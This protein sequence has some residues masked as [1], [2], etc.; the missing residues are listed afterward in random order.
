[1]SKP[2][3]AGAATAW[4]ADP[5]A[6]WRAASA[7]ATDAVQRGVLFADIERQVGDQYFAQRASKT[8]NVLHFPSAFV[9]SGLDLPRPV[10]YGLVRILPPENQPCDPAKRP[11]VVVDPR[12]GHGPG[13]GGFKP[14]SE[15]G[16]A[17]AA[18]H[19]CYFV[20]FLPDPVPGQ[21]VEDVMRAE[22]AFLRR[23][24]ELHPESEGKPAV[25]GNCQA[26]WQILMTA[27]VW[28]EL[29]GPIIVAGAPLSYWAGDNPMRY[30]GGLLGGSWLT[31]L[32]SDLGHGRFD[33]ANLVQNFEQLDPANTLWSKPYK[34][35]ANADTE[36]ERYIDFEKYWGGY[37][38][39]NDVE[40]QYIVDQLFIGNKLSTAQLLTSDGVRID[41]RNIRSPILVFCSY[42][43]NITPPAQALGWI[44][45]LYASD[46]DVRGH[47]QT[48]IF[49]THDS[50]GHL[51]I[52]VSGAVGGKQHRKFA[53]AIEQINLLP[54]G[55]YRASVDDATP[56]EQQLL[57]DPYLLSVRASG[58]DE[59]RAIVKP[60]AQS[61]RRFDAAARVSDINLALYRST[62]QPWVRALS[63]AQSAHWLQALHPMRL[64]F[65]AWSSL[66]P[67]APLV[68]ACA[69]SVRQQRRPVAEDNPF[70]QLQQRFS[71]AMENSLDRFRDRRDNLYALWFDM[72]YGT[73]FMQA[74]AG[75]EDGDGAPV[76]PHPGA[77]PEHLALLRERLQQI[78]QSVDRGGVLEATLRGLL[79]VLAQRRSVDERYYHLAAQLLEQ[80]APGRWSQAELRA[81]IREQALVLMHCGSAA[82]DAIPQL[83]RDTPADTIREAAAAITRMAAI[84]AGQ[85]DDDA[86][87][88]AALQRVQQLFEQAAAAQQPP[89]APPKA[90]PRGRKGER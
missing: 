8:P 89:A 34:V 78:E 7:Y 25:I 71:A 26:G 24:A 90:A 46:D 20:G 88:A 85:G 22:A 19:P 65:E 13:I 82:I 32:T 61:E 18:G 5:L 84:D 17:L 29:F 35:Y 55:I 80:S 31:A 75:H 49:S 36:A 59:I 40:M 14:Q 62:L 50:I 72:L 39:L 3:Q 1:M 15:I 74:L 21:T 77:T 47:D 64:Q 30:T 44:T 45:D 83:L 70:L 63:T 23:V 9:M 16:A 81:A 42:G 27:S 12:A 48:I 76:R 41:L 58:L 60:D 66:H 52:F 51:G 2:S 57:H 79:S 10:N 86:A 37:V 87:V 69:E 43:D 56:Q 54:A 68:R 4:P 6:W 73:P 38:F 53:S 33:G 11:F 67:L 28:P